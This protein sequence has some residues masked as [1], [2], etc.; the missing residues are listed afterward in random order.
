MVRGKFYLRCTRKFYEQRRIIYKVS[1]QKKSISHSLRDI[2]LLFFVSCIREELAYIFAEF[3]SV[4][5]HQMRSLIQVIPEF[6]PNLLSDISE[7]RPPFRLRRYVK[8]SF[9]TQVL[10]Y[11]G[12][13]LRHLELLEQHLKNG[14][15]VILL[16][17]HIKS[18][19][20]QS[21]VT[22]LGYRIHPNQRYVYDP[23]LP[24]DPHQTIGNTM[25]TTTQLLSFRSQ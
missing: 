3:L 13:Q 15:A 5:K 19:F 22:V 11:D 18:T 1:L 24:P 23:S 4:S 16:G 9:E 12:S 17:S 20:A 10:T 2:F 21:Y 6:D 25:R 8:S 14:H 7:Y